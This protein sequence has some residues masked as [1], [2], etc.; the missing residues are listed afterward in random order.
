MW[1]QK[2]D[3]VSSDGSESENSPRTLF[4]LEEVV[5][6]EPSPFLSFFKSKSRDIEEKK[7]DG[8]E[9]KISEKDPASNRKGSFNEGGRP[10][11]L[12]KLSLS[13]EL[14]LGESLS[15]SSPP[16]TC[17][18]VASSTNSNDANLLQKRLR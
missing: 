9:K 18:L 15:K 16:S 8:E 1:S 2:G 10:G 7:S 11:F 5:E 12:R 4:L 6:K 14:P 13:R 3:S 17:P